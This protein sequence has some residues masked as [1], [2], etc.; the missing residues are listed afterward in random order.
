MSE[1][2][3]LNVKVCFW[4]WWSWKSPRKDFRRSHGSKVQRNW[5]ASVS[6]EQHCLHTYKRSCGVYYE[7]LFPS[8]ICEA[9]GTFSYVLR[10]SVMSKCRLRPELYQANGWRVEVA[11]Q[12][13]I[14]LGG[15]PAFTNSLQ[16]IRWRFY[17]LR[18]VSWQ[19]SPT[20]GCQITWNFFKDNMFFKRYG[21]LLW[22]VSAVGAKRVCAPPLEIGTKNQNVR[23]SEVSISIPIN[24]N[25]AMTLYLLVWH[26]HCTKA[27]FTVLVWCSDELAVHSFPLLRLQ[28]H[29]VKLASSSAH[30]LIWWGG[31]RCQFAM[32]PTLHRAIL[33][34]SITFAYVHLRGNKSKVSSFASTS[35]SSEYSHFCD[36][37]YTVVILSTWFYV[38]FLRF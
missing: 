27:R 20:W 19:Q 31:M 10:E 6:W 5:L 24:L 25:L 21:G 13:L 12:I 2:L 3:W 30:R 9:T 35:N 17:W 38:V 34:K 33:R 18:L 37:A 28:T 8:T 4:K 15:I 36:C 29:V 26:S 16:L 7:F 14:I 32:N 11:K 23:I 22:W 1:K